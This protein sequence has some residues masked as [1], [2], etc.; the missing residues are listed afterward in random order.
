MSNASEDLQIA[1][2]KGMEQLCETS[3]SLPIL[4]PKPTGDSKTEGQGQDGGDEAK[5]D[6]TTGDS[7]KNNNKEDDLA[8]SIEDASENINLHLDV[9]R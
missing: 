9:D 8:G 5:N 3:T 1:F 6:A 2:T 7:D 4:A